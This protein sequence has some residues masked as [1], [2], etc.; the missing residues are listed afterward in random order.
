MNSFNVEDMLRARRTCSIVN[1][2]SS[3]SSVNRTVGYTSGVNKY[4]GN[5]YWAWRSVI[6]NQF[7]VLIS[8]K[9]HNLVLFV[10]VSFYINSYFIIIV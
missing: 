7:I 4:S 5:M 1:P 10:L 9:Y 2:V 3:R 6:D 8:Y